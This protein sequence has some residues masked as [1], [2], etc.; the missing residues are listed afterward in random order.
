MRAFQIVSPRSY[1][2][3]D[4]IDTPTVGDGEVLIRIKKLGFCGSDL[5]TFRGKNPLVIYPRIPGHEIV[6]T[7]AEVGTHVPSHLRIG[8]IVTVMPYTSCG[9][10]TACREGRENACKNNETLGVQRDGGFREYIVVPHET[11]VTGVSDLPLQS[12]C[13][14]EP[15]AVGFHAAKRGAIRSGDYTLVIGCGMVGI[16][17]IVGSRRRGSIVIAVDIDD[18][19]LDLARKAGAEF[20]INSAVDDLPRRVLEIT[21]GDGPKVCIEAVGLEATFRLAVE[22]TSFCG[23]VVYVGYAKNPVSYDTKLFVMKELDIRGSRNANR[24]DFREA[25]EAI[26]DDTIPTE[27]LITKELDFEEAGAALE[28]W[29]ANPGNVSKILVSLA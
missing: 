6:G 19:K 14:I 9:T 8:D 12:V 21:N 4:D 24:E 26:R 10:C 13:L 23:R 27:G 11:L 3:F 16:G 2:F 17:T 28:Y 1:R 7:I 20:A 18:S 22:V 15:L 29:D 5:N 25:L